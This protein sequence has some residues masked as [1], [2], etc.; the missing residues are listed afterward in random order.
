MV[1]RRDNRIRAGLNADEPS[2]Y[3]DRT[4]LELF[5]TDRSWRSDEAARQVGVSIYT[6]INPLTNL[7]DHGLVDRHKRPGDRYTTWERTRAGE[8]YATLRGQGVSPLEA[9]RQA[10]DVD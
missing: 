9:L 6:V 2:Q 8:R 10:D 7:C 4:F 5:T 1:S 3:M